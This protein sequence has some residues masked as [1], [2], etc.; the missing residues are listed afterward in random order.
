MLLK[1]KEFQRNCSPDYY[2]E[3]SIDF[4]KQKSGGNDNISEAK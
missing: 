2:L 3:S 4:S 1:K